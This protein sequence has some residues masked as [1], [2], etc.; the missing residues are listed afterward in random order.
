MDSTKILLDIMKEPTG[1][2]PPLTSAL[3]AV[4]ALTKHYEVLV[5]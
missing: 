4:N 2:F 3:G 5:E 1:R